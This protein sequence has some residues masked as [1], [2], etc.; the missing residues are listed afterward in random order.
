MASD[1]ETDKPRPFYG[2]R[3]LAAL[4]PALLRPAFR[5]RAPATAQV[6][7]DWEV[8]VGPRLAALTTP[9][10]LSAGTLAIGCAGPVATELQHVA[11]ELRGRIN[12]HLG[13]A[14]VTRLRFVQA[15]A[16]AIP[17]PAPPARPPAVVAVPG[18]PPGELRDALERLGRAVLTDRPLGGTANPP[19]A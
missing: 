15:A 8:I 3:P 18:L 10:R 6:L 12:A 7:A 5:R 2:P 1:G 16:R 19:T 13:Q 11:D 4:V 14:T 9:L 17:P